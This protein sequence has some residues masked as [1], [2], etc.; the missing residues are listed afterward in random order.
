[1]LTD[2]SKL[3]DYEPGGGFRFG[4][5]GRG[6]SQGAPVDVEGNPI[7]YHAPRHY[8][9]AKSDG[10]RWRWALAQ[11]GEFSV[12]KKN[13][14]ALQLADFLHSQFGVQTLAAYGRSFSSDESLAA[15]LSVR[16]LTD[17]ETL[18]RLA[19]GVKRFR[20]PDEF[21]Y[22]K[23]YRQVA[24]DGNRSAATRALQA[25][26]SIYENRR[27]YP[28]AADVWREL[29]RRF[30]RGPQNTWQ[31]RLDQIV[32]NWGRFEPT[33]TLPAIGGR[34]IPFR[35]RNGKRLEL[36]AHAIKIES[37]LGD[38]KAYLK[39]RPKS[40]DG[41][42]INIAEIGYRL[43]EQNQTQYL[44][45]RVAQWKL[46]LQPRPEHL[47]RQIDVALPLQKA[48]AYLVTARVD[49][50]NISRIVLWIA[51]TALVHKPM[52]S[53]GLYFVADAVTGR[54]IA[55]ANIEF[56]GY[57]V[58][59]RVRNQFD[60]LTANFAELTDAQGQ[61]LADKRQLLPEYQW[62][63]IARAGE[64]L[65]FL[66]F[67]GVW[68]R[69][70]DEVDA[71]QGQQTAFGITDRPVYRPGQTMK[72]KLWAEEVRYDA[73]LSSKFAGQTF[74]IRLTNPRGETLLEKSY[75]ADTFGGFDGEFRLPDDA[76]LGQYSLGIIDRNDVSGAASFRVE[77]YKKPE[78][79]VTVA[80]PT[81]PAALGDKF[82]AT[83]KASYYFGGPVTQASVHYTV[84]RTAYAE[85]WYPLGLWDW[86][87][88][89]GYWWFW[90]DWTWYPGWSTWG[91]P[92]PFFSWL[93]AHRGRPKSSPMPRSR[94]AP[95]ERFRS[96][97]TRRS[98]KLSTAI[99]ISVTRFE[100]KSSTSLAARS[101]ARARCSLRASRSRSLSGPT[102]VT[103]TPAT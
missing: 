13:Q 84:T 25:L 81:E 43:V 91:H 63:A 22:L 68:Y 86:C 14:A 70:G 24:R 5:F 89:R 56:F 65:A 26:A 3:P 98:Q 11:V 72:W 103:T 77:E 73:P 62:T 58:E 29:I 9:E 47:D 31:K 41:S 87:F 51:D 35:F 100:R 33:P 75:T 16:T 18:A 21:N 85:R 52:R 101:S 61:A 30:G 67:E 10:E 76:A 37:L 45:E 8:D 7:F 32:G 59:N 102:G 17:D 50:G 2:L 53:G 4:R 6:Q 66:G 39:S 64:R 12:A 34:T 93:R 49:G 83:I 19:T 69:S 95:T 40:L 99:P 1:M 20:L 23:I 90:P 71:Y 96:P 82:I 48:G 36:E 42:K 79:E 80:A 97:S 74:K 78:F 28:K 44:G 54:P 27:Q 38:V 46:D 15:P 88:G 60:V 92:R 57:K 94:S 55:N